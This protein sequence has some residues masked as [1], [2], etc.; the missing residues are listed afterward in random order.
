VV[1]YTFHESA[2][3]GLTVGG[4]L[5]YSGSNYADDANTFKNEGYCALDLALRY[6]R[7]AWHYSLNVGNVADKVQLIGDTFGFYRSAG[8]TIRASVEWEF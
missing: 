4:G 7:G 1:N 3:R 6:S 5:R 8:R 2:L